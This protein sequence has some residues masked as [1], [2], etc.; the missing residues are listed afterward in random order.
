MNLQRCSACHGVAPK[1]SVV[2]W[3]ACVGRVTGDFDL[4][5]LFGFVTV[6][7]SNRHPGGGN[8]A[9]RGLPIG[10]S[11]LLLDEGDSLKQVA[12][13]VPAREPNVNQKK[14]RQ[15]TTVTELPCAYEEFMK[16]ENRL[17]ERNLADVSLGGDPVF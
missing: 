2:R 1:E 13:V 4:D 5:Y 10:L 15:H 12:R 14:E 17:F 7:T 11:I 9:W 6:L 8:E 16:H 3:T